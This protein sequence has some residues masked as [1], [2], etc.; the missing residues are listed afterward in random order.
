MTCVL[1]PFLLACPTSG[2]RG[3]LVVLTAPFE[4]IDHELH[5]VVSFDEPS[6]A[7]TI[8][9]NVTVT[10]EDAEALLLLPDETDVRGTSIGR[11]ASGFPLHG[12]SSWFPAIGAHCVEGTCEVG[13]TV[14][15]TP[16][17]ASTEASE[18]VDIRVRAEG[19]YEDAYP[20]SARLE[21]MVDGERAI[22]ATPGG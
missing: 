7:E 17:P 11:G 21:L 6:L 9:G 8:S 3:A 4:T 15:V 12:S 5:F 20:A 1:S 14:V 18:S 22:R 10:V 16:D 2:W 19:P 13:Y